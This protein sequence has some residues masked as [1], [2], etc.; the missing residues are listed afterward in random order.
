MVWAIPFFFTERHRIADKNR[1]HG[2]EFFV[3]GSSTSQ[4]TPA[5]DDIKVNYGIQGGLLL[6]SVLGQAA[7]SAH[8]HK[9]RP[10]M[11]L[12]RKFEARLCN[13]R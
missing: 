8:P 6:V 11:N 10:A 1:L 12:K 13:H 9:T 3:K 7:S 5:F 2:A 4:E